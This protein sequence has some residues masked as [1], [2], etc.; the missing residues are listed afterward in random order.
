[1]WP[2]KRSSISKPTSVQ[3]LIDSDEDT[4]P[5]LPSCA[6]HPPGLS[7]II[8]HPNVWYLAEVHLVRC[9]THHDH[10][11]STIKFYF[12]KPPIPSEA[13]SFV[14]TKTFLFSKARLRMRKLFNKIDNQGMVNSSKEGN[15]V[16]GLAPN[17]YHLM[18]HSSDKE[19]RI[20]RKR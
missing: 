8:S 4:T 19:F 6:S 1:M 18:H 5:R 9:W 20:I 11:G 12:W 10:D 14:K 17:S 16:I 13:S 2:V 3:S 7:F 15:A